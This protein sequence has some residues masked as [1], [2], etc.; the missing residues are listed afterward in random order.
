V[1]AKPLQ[2]TSAAELASLVGKE[3]G[4]TGWKVITQRKIDAFAEATEDEGWIH[5]DRSL[6][7]AGPFGS[8]IAHGLLTLG[9]G[10]VFTAELVSYD[11]FAHVLNYGYERVRFPAP[12]PVESRVRMRLGVDSAEEVDGGA[13]VSMTQVYER[14]GLERPVCV[15]RWM[16]RFVERQTRV[17]SRADAP[18]T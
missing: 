1:A 12:L 15:A 3:L 6:A 13:Q 5:V 8:T 7:A 11:G 18:S 14:D 2:P 4:P 16:A 17:G 10:P 9:L